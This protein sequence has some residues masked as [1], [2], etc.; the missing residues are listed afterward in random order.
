MRLR[1]VK[2]KAVGT[3]T[4]TGTD[5]ST[6]VN[7]KNR[8]NARRP[9]ARARLHLIAAGGHVFRLGRFRVPAVAPGE[10][11]R[12]RVRTAAPMAAPAGRYAVRVCLRPRSSGHCRTSRRTVVI[13]PA[14]LVAS[15]PLVTFSAIIPGTTSD[16]QSLTITN[17]GHARTGRLELEATGDGTFAVD[18][19]TCSASLPPNA[20]CQV[21]V[22]FSPDVVGSAAG[23]LLISGR[24]AG[25]LSVPLTG[26]GQGAAV[27][28]ISPDR[29]HFN[30]SLVGSHSAPLELTVT[31]E[32]TDS[33]GVPTVGLGA[34][35]DD[36]FEII[37]DTCTEPLAPEGSCLVTVVFS[38]EVAGDATNQLE[39]SASP[40]G[41]VSSSL[42]GTGLAASSLSLTPGNAAFGPALVG[43]T[44]AAQSFTV[45]NNGGV[46]SGVPS[47]ALEGVN[48]GQFTVVSNG[49]TTAL[50]AA[51]SCLVMVAFS[52]T[53]PGEAAATYVPPLRR[54]VRSTANSPEPAKRRR[55]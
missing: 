52:P 53:V 54:A 37:D 29:V 11:H 4:A 21:A 12:M 34:A 28:S 23:A 46:P 20:S 31:N 49:C 50:P 1:I 13:A 24:R 16:A 43:V 39:V 9:A 42:S 17:Q 7:V 10:R 38:P 51:G 47:V 2:V 45:T 55:R 26:S 36:E 14:L 19:S 15:P 44:P 27:L 30:D 33:T 41:S 40:G 22:V 25:S 5:V 18:T 6:I 35:L 48:P 3:P 32:G 8:T